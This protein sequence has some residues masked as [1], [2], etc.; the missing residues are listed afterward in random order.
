MGV[1]RVGC[2]CSG[3]RLAC[4]ISSSEGRGSFIGFDRRVPASRPVTRT[5]TLR[6]GPEVAI[7]HTRD[8]RPALAT[9][10]A[11]AHWQCPSG[12]LVPLYDMRRFWIRNGNATNMACPEIVRDLQACIADDN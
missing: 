8:A 10:T 11:D 9:A 1:Q 6:H 4:A 2:G 3:R 5:I 12:V 7:A